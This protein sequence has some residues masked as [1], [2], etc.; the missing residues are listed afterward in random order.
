MYKKYKEEVC[1]MLD[2]LSDDNPLWRTLYA[3]LLRNH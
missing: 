2:K 3:I 1:R